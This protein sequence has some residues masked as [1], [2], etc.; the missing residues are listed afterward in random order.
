MVY[1][2]DN[3]FKYALEVRDSS[4]SNDKVYDFLKNNKITLTRSIRDELRTPSIIP[5]DQLYVRFIGD[6]SIN[7]KD[8]GKIVK[9]RKKM[10]N[11][12][13]YLLLIL[14]F[15]LEAPVFNGAF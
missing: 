6:R 14:L 8:F 10:T 5:L 2:L 15:P 13:N 4:W 12:Y 1:R 3:R 9:D 7:D 11:V